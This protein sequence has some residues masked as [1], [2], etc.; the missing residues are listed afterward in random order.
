MKSYWLRVAKTFGLCAILVGGVPAAKATT[1]NLNFSSLNI[2]GTITTNGNTGAL[3]AAD[4]TA[5][6]FDQTA[7]TVHYPVNMDSTGPTSSLTLTGNA[8]TATATQ[9]FFNFGDANPGF[10]NF[11]SDGWPGT[12]VNDHGLSLEFCSASGASP[13]RD[14]NN[15]QSN[16]AV[17]FVLIAGGCC[18]TSGGLPETGNA[19]IATAAAPVPGP[20]VGAGLPGLILASGGLLAWWRRRSS[21]QIAP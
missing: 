1:Y 16:S 20:V 7:D 9:L 21:A 13:C 11:T 5:W 6:H 18:S 15:N 2:S 10:L 12:L 17:L 8:L 14:Q 19:V 3:S 4:I